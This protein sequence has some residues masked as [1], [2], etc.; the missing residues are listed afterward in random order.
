MTTPR[1]RCGGLALVL[2]AGMA[3]QAAAAGLRD[4]VVL[5]APAR[6]MAAA[7]GSRATV[8]QIGDGRLLAPTRQALFLSRQGGRCTWP[9]KSRLAT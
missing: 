6:S 3:M 5:C 2:T 7:S 9:A 1:R 8:R 4:G